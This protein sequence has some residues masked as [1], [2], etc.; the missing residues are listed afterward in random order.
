[1]HND[2]FTVSLPDSLRTFLDGEREERGLE[3][4]DD[5]VEVLLREAWARRPAR[6]Y[7]EVVKAGDA[8]NA[9]DDENEEGSVK[10]TLTRLRDDEFRELARTCIAINDLHEV[11]L[12]M[13]SRDRP[14]LAQTYAVCMTCFGERGRLFDDWKGGFSFPLSLTIEGDDRKPAYLI[15]L[16]NYRSGISFQILQ[17][18]EHDDPRLKGHCLYEHNDPK[19]PTK[20]LSFLIF[21]LIGFIQGFSE[22]FSWHS[23]YL[24][25]V[26]SNLILYGYSPSEGFFN[27]QFEDHHEYEAVLKTLSETLPTPKY[28]SSV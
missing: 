7:V 26:Q 28:Y 15:N 19:F 13:M 24:L 4:V 21:Y 12:A 23:P 11:S 17:S 8:N 9:C 1:M 10:C 3:S 25:Q 2:R 6:M 16:Y 27:R 14:L 20:R 18:V 5:C 22:S